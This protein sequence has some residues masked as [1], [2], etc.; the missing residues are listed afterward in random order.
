MSQ[1]IQ[2]PSAAR[3][4]S[5][6]VLAEM[7][8]LNYRAR[9]L[10]DSVLHGMHRS[11]HHGTSVEFSEHKKYSPGDDVRHLD[12]RAYAR[13]DRD[14]IKQ[15]EDEANLSALIVVDISGSMRY[16]QEGERKILSK[17]D[18]AMTCAGA[19]AYVL[20]RQGDAVGLA[21][22]ADR[23][24]IEV[25]PR[26]RRGQLQEIFSKLETLE[27]K[28]PTQLTSAL[29]ALAEGMSKRMCLILFSDLLDT[30]AEAMQALAR[31]SARR[32]DVTLFHVMDPDELDF[33]F[34]GS[35]LFT[36]L[37]GTRS[38]PIDAQ[39]IKDAYL[40]EVRQFLFDVKSRARS[41][42]VEYELVR[43]DQSPTKLL[44]R[45]LSSR[46]FTRRTVR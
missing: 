11:K 33:P 6:Q 40:E 39:A 44:S 32:H 41:S 19:L 12:W 18:Y 24:R 45:Y 8:A 2:N 5:V 16:R 20:A 25:P 43:T 30:N 38:V 34:E 27:S 13:H 22:F 4:I 15:F 37:E 17:Q 35:T 36:D 21:S 10:A 29:N 26:A 14:Y 7:G 23:F 1:D 46:T 42:R 3:T 9:T 28:G 31:V